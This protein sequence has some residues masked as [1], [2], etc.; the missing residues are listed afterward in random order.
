MPS[1][2]SVPGHRSE[3]RQELRPTAENAGE[4][5]DDFRHEAVSGQ[6]P[7]GQQDTIRRGY[8][9]DQF[10]AKTSHGNIMIS[11][12]AQELSTDGRYLVA[13]FDSPTAI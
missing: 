9:G 3:A 1:G 2:G 13:R 5:L 10:A 8:A 6:K 12:S 4:S 7:G 11:S